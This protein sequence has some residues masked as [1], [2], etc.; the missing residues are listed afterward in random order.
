VSD[1]IFHGIATVTAGAGRIGIV[2]LPDAEAIEEIAAWGATLIVSM[3]T[4]REMD[5]PLAPHL[6]RI[7]ADWDHLPIVDFGAPDP[8]IQRQWLE[9]SAAI[10]ARLDAGEGVIVHCRGGCGRSGMIALRLLVERGE[11]PQ[12]AQAR[13]RAVRPCAVETRAQYDWAAAGAP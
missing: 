2:P 1:G 4:V 3:T 5:G 11:A 10:H 6:E 12:A 9:S 7:G 13:M 8:P